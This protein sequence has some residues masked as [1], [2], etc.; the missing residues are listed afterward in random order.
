MKAFMVTC[1]EYSDYGICGIFSTKEHAEKYI[2]VRLRS[3][4][5]LY[6]EFNDVEE[7]ELDSY[8]EFNYSNDNI[9]RGYMDED[10][11][12][13]GDITISNDM[14]HHANSFSVQ[15][16]IRINQQLIMYYIVRANSPQ[17]AV[18]IA[19]DKRSQII[20]NN[21]FVDRYRDWK[22]DRP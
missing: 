17:R 6:T 22:C 13:I 9:Y 12:T 19:N 18:K 20:S 21:N 5:M 10:G 8:N 1:G 2:E 11:N 4:D 14:I 3:D 15:K 7:I 16:D